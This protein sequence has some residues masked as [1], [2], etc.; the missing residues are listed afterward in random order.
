MAVSADGETR[1]G[2]G[3]TELLREAGEETGSDLHIFKI[4]PR[5]VG[6]WL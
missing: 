3:V 2:Q 1:L 4:G 6:G 5:V